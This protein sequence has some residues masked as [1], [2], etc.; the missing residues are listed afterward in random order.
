MIRR[1]SRTFLLAERIYEDYLL[2]K[3]VLKSVEPENFVEKWLARNFDG[4]S[5]EFENE[6]WKCFLESLR[7][8]K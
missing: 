4:V 6:V 1:E 8:K 3:K 5:K 2:S 7:K